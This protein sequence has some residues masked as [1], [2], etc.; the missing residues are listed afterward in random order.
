MTAAHFDA[1]LN[2]L[3]AELVKPSGPKPQWK[4]TLCGSLPI[5]ID[6]QAKWWH[7][8]K[9]VTRQSIVKLWASVLK[10]DYGEPQDFLLPNYR[11]V[12]PVEDIQIYVEDAPFV[13]T[14][15]Q[16]HMIGDESVI[17]AIDNLGRAWPVCEQFPL[18]LREY[19]SQTVPYVVLARNLLA[20]VQRNVFYQWAERV[21]ENAGTYWLMSAKTSFKLA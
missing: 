10:V 17:V 2:L 19:Q 4:P 15:W 5:R 8:G 3:I 18:I 14:H 1:A 11:L 20:R 7:D 13:I 6:A 9:E 16:E 21:T 12:T